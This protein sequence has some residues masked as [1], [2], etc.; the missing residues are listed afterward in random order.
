[1]VS[2]Y[3]LRR[4]ACEFKTAFKNLEQ[5]AKASVLFVC[6]HGS[7]KSLIAARHF[8]R[9][10]R[11]EGVDLSAASAGMEPDATVPPHVVAGLARDGFDVSAAVPA[12]VT[13]EAVTTADYLVSFGCDL[14]ALGG[15]PHVKR[16]DD[17]PAVSDGYDTARSAIELRARALLE[18]ILA[19]PASR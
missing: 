3:Y 1:V 10:A 12:K 15:G 2:W 16:W 8:E 6:L 5:M 19:S 17:V 13:Q 14:D 18:E 11:A 7:A 9:L 4:F